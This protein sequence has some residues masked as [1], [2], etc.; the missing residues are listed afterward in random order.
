MPLFIW[1][2]RPSG[3]LALQRLS[4]FSQ[5]RGAIFLWVLPLA[6][7]CTVIDPF[8]ILTP[9]WSEA[10]IRLTMFPLPVIYGYLIFADHGIQQA[11]ICHRRASLT[12]SVI[13]TFIPPLVAL[14]ISEWGWKF[15]LLSY[16]VLMFF[17]SLLIWCYLLAAFGYGMRYLTGS[18]PLLSYANEAVLPIYIL[19]QPIILL[20]GYFIIPLQLPILVKYLIIAPLAFGISLGLFEYAI[21]RV[22]L[23]RAAFGLKVRKGNTPGVY[24]VSQPSA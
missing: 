4:R 7:L 8:S 1:L 19:H 18:K 11:I 24:M 15:N 13:L 6:V 5:R 9:G 2:K 12:I 14:G 10:L 21:R 17:A 16:M 20:L 3:Q 22:K 23:L